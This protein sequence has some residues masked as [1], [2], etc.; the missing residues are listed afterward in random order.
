MSRQHASVA[1]NDTALLVDEDRNRPAPF[2][3]RRRDLVDLLR[4]VRAGIAYGISAATA[5]RSTLSAGHSG[6]KIFS[7]GI[8]VVPRSLRPRRP[9]RLA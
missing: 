6:C 2:A 8:W 4:A 3:D 7:P 1:S 9:A 5:R